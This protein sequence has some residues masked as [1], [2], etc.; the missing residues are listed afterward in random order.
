MTPYIEP[1]GKK[2]GQ[3]VS[4]MPLV[5]VVSRAASP[6]A[7]NR[8]L[9]EHSPPLLSTP[10]ERAP[11]DPRTLRPKAVLLF[12]GTHRG[13]LAAAKPHTRR[14]R[15]KR[16]CCRR[17][18]DSSHG[19]PRCASC[20]VLLLPALPTT[21]PTSAVSSFWHASGRTQPVG[22]HSHAASVRLPPACA[23]PPLPGDSKRPPL[24][25]RSRGRPTA[26]CTH[27][28]LTLLPHQCQT[29]WA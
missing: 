18:Y 6:P 1:D 16:V 28:S 12:Y 20:P 2:H 24:R 26:H 22:A 13:P 3:T 9:S 27:Q 4:G 5:T 19:R 11:R 29:L 8:L 7:A 14:A 21:S 17:S 25:R 15:R 10:A 23:R